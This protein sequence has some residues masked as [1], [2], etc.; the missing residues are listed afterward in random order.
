MKL[1]LES[2]RKFMKEE[3]VDPRMKKHL[4]KHPY[5]EPDGLQEKRWQDFDKPKGEWSEISG[6]D[7]EGAKDPLDVDVAEE[8]FAL[9]DNAYKPIGGNF[10]Y[11]SPADLPGKAQYWLAIDIDDDPEPDAVRIGKRK[12]AGLKLTASGHDGKDESKEAF[13]KKTYELL[14]TPGVY[15]EMSKGIAHIM[16]TKMGTPV[17]YI[18]D[19]EMVQKALGPSKTIKWLGAHPFGRYPD[20][21]G[22]YLRDI[23]DKKDE[24]KIMLGTPNV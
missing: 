15:A 11:K 4:D 1:I 8:L 16:L 14:N 5:M 21:D 17:P 6:V 18:D 20:M 3:K 24:L 19:R 22:W 23:G 10:D 7:I 9:I 13:K 12:P 2:W